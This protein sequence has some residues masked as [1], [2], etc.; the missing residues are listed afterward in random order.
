M[1]L[2]PRI[3]LLIPQAFDGVEAGGVDGGDHAADDADQAENDGGYTEAAQVD[4]EVDVAGLEAVAEGAH[5]GQGADG[6][7]NDVGD[8]DAA[9]RLRRR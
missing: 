8:S 4:V 6:P 1:P 5:Q 7:R 3:F 9:R 2:P